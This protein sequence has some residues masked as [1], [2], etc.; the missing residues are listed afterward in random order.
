M[1]SGI[2]NASRSIVAAA[3][4]LAFGLT[5]DLAFTRP[6]A[7][8]LEALELQRNRLVGELQAVESRDAELRALAH[9]LGYASISG[10][11]DSLGTQD[12]IA[13]LT[14]AVEA[15]SLTR[16]E[17]STRATKDV[18]ALHRT[19]FL[20]VVRGPFHRVS[21]FLMDLEAGARLTTI[22]GLVVSPAGSNAT[23]EARINLSVY[24]PK[25]DRPR[26]SAADES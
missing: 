24:D 14:G 12:P 17:L 22:D 19:E 26:G 11:L 6:Q 7:T 9:A 2:A 3:G 16:G 13:F 5:A 1:K 23:V 21:R 8:R 10:A 20:L 18:G 4:V 15:A 25:P